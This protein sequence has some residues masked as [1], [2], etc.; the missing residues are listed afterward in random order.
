MAI[1]KIGG[2]DMP[3][4]SK[5]NVTLQDIDSENTS[6]TETGQLVRD[7]IRASV[8]K[9]EIAWQVEHS[10]IKIITD[11]LSPAKFSVNFYDPT[12]NAHPTKDMYCGDRNGNLLVYKAFAPS[13]SLWE[14]ATSLIEY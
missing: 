7:R 12:T 3:A 2:V 13:K 6:R 10:Q 14:I 11:A 5:Y 4:P 1:I 8:Y 9:I